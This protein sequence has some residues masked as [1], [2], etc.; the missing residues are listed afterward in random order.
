MHTS[1]LCTPCVGVLRGSAHLPDQCKTSCPKMLDSSSCGFG[2]HSRSSPVEVAAESL[3]KLTSSHHVAHMS[4][5]KAGLHP[6][7]P[8]SRLKR[9]PSLNSLLMIV[10]AP[11]AKSSRRTALEHRPSLPTTL[12]GAVDPFS[13]LNPLKGQFGC[14]LW[15]CLCLKVDT[16]LWVLR[17][18]VKTNRNTEALDFPSRSGGSM[19]EAVHARFGG[20]LGA[21][22]EVSAKSIDNLLTQSVEMSSRSRIETGTGSDGHLQFDKPLKDAQGSSRKRTDTGQR[23]TPKSCDLMCA[24]VIRATQLN[25]A[26]GSRRLPKFTE[27]SQPIL[28]VQRSS[29]AGEH[30]GNAPAERPHL[31]LRAFQG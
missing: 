21:P 3:K 17:I 7:R 30:G 1:R 22:N 6:L 31:W 28:Q 5:T 15:G 10:I 20:V 11:C 16:G 19:A 4:T 13:A 24:A 23:Q 2:E 9:I 25:V 29:K 12:R 27:I 18:P 26:E 14:A 8:N